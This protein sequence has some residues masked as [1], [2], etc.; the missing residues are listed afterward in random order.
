[1]VQTQCKKEAKDIIGCEWQFK[2]PL[3]ALSVWNKAGPRYAA[4]FSAAGT[5]IPQKTL[6]VRESELKT[7]RT[8]YTGLSL[9]AKDTSH[10]SPILEPSLAKQ[11]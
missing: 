8:P 3:S 5:K 6:I 10:P 9:W 4:T 1:M 7:H 2:A 11:D